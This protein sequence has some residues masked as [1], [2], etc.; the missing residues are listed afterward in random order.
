M[1]GAPKFVS[2]SVTKAGG[3]GLVDIDGDG[4]FDEQ[5]GMKI[6]VQAAHP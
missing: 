6:D 3:A 1:I 4:V 5:Y 2:S